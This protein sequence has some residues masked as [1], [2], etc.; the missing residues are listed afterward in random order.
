MA[1]AAGEPVRRSPEWLWIAAVLLALLLVARHVLAS[2]SWL[3]E[4]WQLWISGAPSIH[5]VDRL[6][7][8]AHPPWF[9]LLARII[10]SATG[11]A[12]L[13]AR[14]VNFV[15]ATAVLAAGLWRMRS[16]DSGLRWRI[17]LL[18]AASG[19]AVGMTDLAASFR[20]Y[21]WL[22]IL[23]GLQAALL[24]ALAL[25]RPVPPLLAGAV[26]AASVAIHYVHAAG[27]IAIALVSLAVAWR[28]Q[29]A[30]MRGLAAGL[31]LGMALDLATG[32]IQLPH[33]RANF[34][35]NWIAL[36]GGGGA[37]ASLAAVGAS[38]LTGN[39]IASALL[40]VGLIARRSKPALVVLAPIPLAFAAWAVMDAG[41]PLLVPRY[42]ATVTALLA[43]AAA[44]V[45]WE[46]AL[47]PAVN[48]IVAFF[49]AAQPLAS[50]LM[51]PALAGWEAGARVAAAAVRACPEARLYAVSAWRYRDR[52]DS[53]T[54]RF[55]EPVIGFAYRKV[56]HAFGLS[57][58]FV[59]SPT[60]LEP[61]RCPAIVWIE[62]AH[63]IDEVPVRTILERGR[64]YAPADAVTRITP[65]PNGA[66]LLIS[67]ADRL[68]PR[69]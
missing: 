1:R 60:A 34:D 38:F 48:A 16:V 58:R 20:A 24:A 57:P 37:A 65:T 53:K 52:Q 43:T 31:V 8:D 28:G 36:S 33:W 27:A 44:V 66:V 21:P 13:P 41:A 51:R 45:W 35:V 17:L 19:G 64:L 10:L 5:V 55:E 15:C 49:A 25:H 32:L 69:P 56:G 30:A 23:A 7:A 54:A 50:S 3:D 46:L 67:P 61:G 59:T 6:A 11:G 22:I 63:G 26:T 42:M 40:A 62:A 2:G 14:L 9:S 18:I 12:I 29:R 47:A 68:Q 39:F 4:Y